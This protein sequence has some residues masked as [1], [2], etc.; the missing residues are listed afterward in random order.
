MENKSMCS[1]H[2]ENLQAGVEQVEIDLLAVLLH[3]EGVNCSLQASQPITEVQFMVDETPHARITYPWNP[4]HAETD[5]IFTQQA[6]ALNL[7]DWQADEIADRTNAFFAQID[8]LWSAT[9]L[10]T[11]LADRFVNRIPSNLLTAIVERAQQIATTSAA[12]ADQLIECVQ[13]LLPNLVVEDIEVLARPLAYAMRDGSEA[14]QATLQRIRPVAW[15]EL[16]EIEQA[17]LS[18]AIARSALD[19]LKQVGK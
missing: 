11:T 9:S 10:H 12:L 15:E 5:T 8:K 14:V 1:D 6:Q 13:D 3:A 4:T 19:E 7:D 2:P 18:L 16:S 17:R